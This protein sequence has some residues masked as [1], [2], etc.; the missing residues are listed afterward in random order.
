MTSVGRASAVGP[1]GA[2]LEYRKEQTPGE[3]VCEGNSSVTEE[4]EPG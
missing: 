3:H 2:V 1:S 4:A